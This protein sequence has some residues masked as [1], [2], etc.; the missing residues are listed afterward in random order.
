M[1]DSAV[2]RPDPGSLVEY[3]GT[4]VS[5]ELNVVW[6]LAS[7]NGSLVLRRPGA[8]DR[9]LQPMRP[10][11]F[12]RHFGPAYEPLVASVDFKRDAAGQITGFTITT[13][14]GEDV[15]RGLQFDRMPIR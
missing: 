2:W 6:Q 13:P 4:Y 10:G 15:V 3:A 11:V 14:P 9:P 8:P 7:R 12:S 1:E 5:E